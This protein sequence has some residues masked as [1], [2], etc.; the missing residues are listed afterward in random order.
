MAYRRGQAETSAT[1]SS[2]TKY[3]LIVQATRPIR[4]KGVGVF[5][6]YLIAARQNNRL[7]QSE[8]LSWFSTALEIV[9]YRS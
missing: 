4:P 6:S 9:K 3:G 2:M 8:R 5:K 1:E 7:V